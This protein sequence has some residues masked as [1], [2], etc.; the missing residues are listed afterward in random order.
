MPNA[1]EISSCNFHE[2]TIANVVIV[3]YI[4]EFHLN[5]FLALPLP[6][7]LLVIYISQATFI[8]CLALSKSAKSKLDRRKSG[9]TKAGRWCLLLIV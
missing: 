1:V 5:S 2:T 4:S 3:L 6:V 8:D 9:E 7:L